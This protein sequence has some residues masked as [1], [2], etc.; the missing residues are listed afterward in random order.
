MLLLDDGL[1]LD[2]VLGLLLFLVLSRKATDAFVL[3]RLDDIWDNRRLLAK[4]PDT[5][6]NLSFKWHLI[7]LA[8]RRLI[9]TAFSFLNFDHLSCKSFI[10]YIGP[11]H[12]S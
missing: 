8:L 2:L 7:A 10:V 4:L 12:V 11:Y 9:P 6:A 5:E 1:L 3:A